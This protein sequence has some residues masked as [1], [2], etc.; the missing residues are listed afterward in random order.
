MSKQI[1]LNAPLSAEDREYLEVRARHDLVAANDAQFADGE[2]VTAYSGLTGGE[3]AFG[4][5]AGSHP[6]GVG[7]GLGSNPLVNP[8]APTSADAEASEGDDSDGYDTMTVEELQD[9]LRD[10][11]LKVGGNK[12]ELI[13]RL[14]NDDA[15]E[16]GDGNEE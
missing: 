8:L 15:E 2:P 9:E 3:P 1:D 14:R 12:S 6:E 16:D 4:V 13:A 7:L 10:R 5:P 11:E